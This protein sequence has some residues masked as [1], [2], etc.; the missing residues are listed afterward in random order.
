MS[1]STGFTK[2]VIQAQNRGSSYGFLAWLFLEGPDRAF[3]E[4]I[5]THGEELAISTLE[6]G[7]GS[8]A[9]L[10]GLREMRSYIAQRSESSM[11]ELCMDLGVQRTR[12][13]R[14]VDPGYG[15]PPPYEAVY[16]CPGDCQENELMLRVSDFYQKAGARLPAGK[17]ERLDYLG[18]ELD[19]MHFMCTEEGGFWIDG[20]KDA[21]VEMRQ[22][23]RSFFQEHLM[24]WVP[25]FCDAAM[26]EPKVAFYHGVV[27]MLRAFLEEEASI[28]FPSQR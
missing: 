2:E 9:I 1:D 26:Q 11:E 28:F 15:P 20:N 17:R 5:M 14:G 24:A 13:V 8:S 3:I 25:G 19:L 6:N 21:A 23:Q 18:L 27:A 22:L 10:S 16:R 12:L 4:R 7:E